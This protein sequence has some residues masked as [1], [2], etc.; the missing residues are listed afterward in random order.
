MDW[1]NVQRFPH[2]SSTVYCR[3]PKIAWSTFAL[4]IFLARMTRTIL[5]AIQ[6]AGEGGEP[7]VV[8]SSRSA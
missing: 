7:P 3:S 2:G 1:E 4:A 8:R 5:R 6:L